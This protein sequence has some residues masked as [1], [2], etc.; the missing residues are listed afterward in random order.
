MVPSEIDTP[1]DVENGTVNG[2]K[3][4]A[5]RKLDHELGIPSHEL[6]MDKFKFL[7]R[8]HYWAADTVTHGPK[9]CVNNIHSY[10]HV[11]NHIFTFTLFCY[12][13]FPF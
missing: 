5:I 8:L 2:V 7:T 12:S 4:A 9:R 6:Q 11:Y 13:L 1:E 3:H 10:I